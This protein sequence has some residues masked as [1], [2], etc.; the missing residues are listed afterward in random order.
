MC[1]LAYPYISQAWTHSTFIIN[2][3]REGGSEG[4]L[5]SNLEAYRASN[6]LTFVGWAVV[7]PVILVT[8]Y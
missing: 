3:C 1:D 4:G 5:I 6:M 8:E 7:T 2:A